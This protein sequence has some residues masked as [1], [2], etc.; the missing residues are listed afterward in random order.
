MDTIDW[1]LDSDPAIRWQ[2]MRDLT[3]ASPAAF[4]AEC[5]RVPREG[6]GVEILAR[7]SEA[8]I[9]CSSRCPITVY[10]RWK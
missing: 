8:T 4:A 3:D 5:A 6:V 9:G 10:A 7:H 2:A 1:L